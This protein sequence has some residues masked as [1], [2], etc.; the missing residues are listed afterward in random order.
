MQQLR[1][2]SS[3][4]NSEICQECPLTLKVW[5]GRVGMLRRGSAVPNR[6]FQAMKDTQM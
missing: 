6:C 5:L 1:K 3:P 4:S 2:V